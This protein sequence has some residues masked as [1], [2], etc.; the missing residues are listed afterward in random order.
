M[1]PDYSL[2][3][4]LEEIV[5]ADDE[6]T[7]HGRTMQPLKPAVRRYAAGAARRRDGVR[8]V[9]PDDDEPLER[10]TT[11]LAQWCQGFLYG[12]GTGGTIEPR[13]IPSNVDEVLR[14][15]THIGRAS[16][17][18]S[19]TAG[20]DEEEAYAEVV[21]YVRVGVQL[22]HDEL[23]ADSRADA[24][25]MRRRPPPDDTTRTID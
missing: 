16:E 5:P 6:T 1:T 19:A 20:E 13:Q 2:E 11:A 4:W 17:S 23:I 7:L 10:R 25:S 24:R 8:A 21:E 3:R 12:F 15:F 14:D 22:I 18:M 9:A